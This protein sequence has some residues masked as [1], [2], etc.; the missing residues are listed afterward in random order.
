[1]GGLGHLTPGVGGE[2]SGVDSVVGSMVGSGWNSGE[3]E[4]STVLFSFADSVGWLVS[5][6]V[7][8]GCVGTQAVGDTE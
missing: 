8:V 7:S 4:A 1:M 3:P 6:V 5:V 2:V